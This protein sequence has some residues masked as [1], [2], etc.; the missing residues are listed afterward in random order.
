MLDAGADLSVRGIVFLS[1]RGEFALAGLAAV[2]NDKAGATVT[3]VRDHR[4]AADGRLRAGQ[5]PGLALIAIAGHRP[6]TAAA[7]RVSES[8]T[9]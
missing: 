6:A 8:M 3:A 7:S 5:L 4:G 9:T 2:R 1:P